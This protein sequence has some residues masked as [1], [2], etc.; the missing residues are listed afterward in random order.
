MRTI[1]NWIS[2]GVHTGLSCTRPWPGQALE[3]TQASHAHDLKWISTGVQ[4]GLPCTR[5]C[6]GYIHL[7][8]SEH[9]QVMFT[10]IHKP[11]HRSVDNRGRH[12]PITQ[13]NIYF[14]HPSYVFILH[15]NTPREINLPTLF[16]SLNLNKQGA[17]EITPTFRKIT[18][19]G[20]QSRKW[21][22]GSFR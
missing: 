14:L 6:T 13:R 10:L 8:A 3:C 1:L 15:F 19:G 16:F 9:I 2:N 21:G 22:R 11:C 4:T 20:P 7:P 18:V 17:A 5:A 12:F